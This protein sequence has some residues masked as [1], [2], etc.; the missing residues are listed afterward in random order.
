MTRVFLCVA[1]FWIVLSIAAF[2]GDQTESMRLW[3]PGNTWALEF[4]YSGFL[5]ADHEITADL[6]GR[7]LSTKDQSDRVILEVTMEPT[8]TMLTSVE[9]RD[10]CM[11]AQEKWPVHRKDFRRYEVGDIA[12]VEYVQGR[13]EETHDGR[14]PNGR[15][16]CVRDSTQIS[17]WI[18]GT[19]MKPSVEELIVRVLESLKIVEVYQ[20]NSYDY[21]L[22]GSKCYLQKNYQLATDFYE[23]GLALEKETRALPRWVWLISVDNLGMAYCLS[24][25]REN[26]RRVFEYG[27]SEEPE[28]PMFHYNLACYFAEEKK[29]DSALA[30]L[31][32][33]Y[34][35]K[36]N[37]L[38][39]E[40]IPD[41]YKDESFRG[42]WSNRDFNR[43]M[44]SVR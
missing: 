10:S 9:Y 5:G 39:G 12:I 26:G 2:A 11:K 3:L 7:S 22:F 33:V 30:C 31:G 23:Q 41:P 40:K 18:A 4:D 21:I 14:Q 34:E 16:Y 17:L 24:G 37:M 13:L 8:F 32:K 19:T 43:F 38:P 27:L 29:L 20:P 35:Y 42:Y 44:K 28:Y 36:A 15:A 1:G 25:D 6:R